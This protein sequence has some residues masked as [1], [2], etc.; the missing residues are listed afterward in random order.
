MREAPPR[1]EPHGF[2]SAQREILRYLKRTPDAS[3]AE[4]AQRSG[5][6]KVAALRHLRE[7]EADRWLERSYRRGGVG[8]PAVCFRLTEGSESL[9]PQA[10]DEISGYALA[11]IE[12]RLGRPAVGELLQERAREVA[13]RNR[14]RLASGDL[15][16]RVSE[17]A[18]LRT[19]EG[20]MAELG[21][22]RRGAVEMHELHCPIRSVAQAY[23]EAC[24]T[25]RRLF[26]SLLHAQIEITHRVVT[27]DPVCHFR[28]RAGEPGR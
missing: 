23:P 28:I 6:S 2:S 24:E 16:A 5:T 12:R 4:I 26:E 25:E 11:F 22:R 17:L 18:R 15:R 20:Y 14:S 7:L 3:L 13:E 19:E 8:R 9:F 27:G 10:Y 21:T 1:P